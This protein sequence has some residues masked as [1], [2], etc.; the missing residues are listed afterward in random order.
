MVVLVV[1]VGLLSQVKQ[2]SSVN[3]VSQD[4]RLGLCRAL[5]N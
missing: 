5:A 3:V 4:A 2:L 1:E